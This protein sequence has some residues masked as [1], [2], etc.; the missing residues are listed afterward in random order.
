MP[1]RDYYDD[2]PELYFRD[3]TEPALKKQIA[4][5]ESALCGVLSAFE[6]MNR[7]IHATERKEIWSYFDY[8]QMGIEKKDLIKWLS[9][10]RE[11]ERKAMA[12]SE[13]KA[14]RIKELEAELKRLKAEKE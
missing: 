13:K 3:F 4:F 11:A 14:R 9:D 5:A 12:E 1:C 6:E 7:H 2:H 8:K 10:H